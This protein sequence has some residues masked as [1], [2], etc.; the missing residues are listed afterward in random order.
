MTEPHNVNISTNT[1]NL[2]TIGLSD[3]LFFVTDGITVSGR[4]G[5]KIDNQ[6]PKYYKSIIVECINN[7]W[8]EPIATVY[9]HELTWE[10]LN[11]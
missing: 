1:A 5:L 11:K 6:C 2:K 7:G 8:I 10:I 9:E 4:A 3:P